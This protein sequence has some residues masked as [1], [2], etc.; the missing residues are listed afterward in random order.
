[1]GFTQTTARG[2]NVKPSVANDETGF[3]DFNFKG[4]IRK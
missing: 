2:G 3:K 4:P 1:M